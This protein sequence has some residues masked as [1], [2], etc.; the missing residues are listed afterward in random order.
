VFT[1]SGTAGARTQEIAK[2]AGV[3]SALLHY[4]FRTKDRLAEAVFRRAAGQLMPAVIRILASDLDLEQKVELPGYILSELAHHPERAGQLFSSATGIAPVQVR[5]LVLG[6]LRR[7]IDE[8]VRKGRMH[9]IAPEQFVVNLL[10][11][12]VFPFAARAMLT[13]LL[14]LDDAGFAKFIDTRRAELAAFFL[15][16]LQP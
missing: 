2:D 14:G 11:L 8:R 16:A 1:R 12:C 3:N 10:A 13:T 5:G 9:P 7:Q 6:G 15:R 4:Y